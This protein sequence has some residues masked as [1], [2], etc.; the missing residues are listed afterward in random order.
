MTDIPKNFREMLKK[1]YPMGLPRV[2]KQRESED[3]TVKVGMLLEDGEAIEAV[4][5]PTRDSATLCLSSQTGCP[6][7]C[8]FCL[9]GQRPGRN[10]SPAE[11]IGQFLMLAQGLEPGRVNVVFMGMGEPLLNLESLL[12][13]LEFL[14]E[15]IS[16]R[17]ITVSTA[18]LTDGITRLAALVPH[19]KLAVSLNAPDDGT[20][21]SLMPLA[22]N[23][24]I[25]SLMKVMESYPRRRGE[26]ITL[27]YVLIRD[28]NTSDYHARTL[29]DLL[30]TRS[31]IFKINLIPYNRV[32]SLPYSEPL[33]E[34]IQRFI[35]VLVRA[36]LTATVR[37]S[38]G[39]E[40]GAACGQLTASP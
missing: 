28:I 10:L 22:K 11:M 5:M 4:K 23:Q 25:N 3:G 16:P 9:T 21:G 17:R 35:R 20:R 34:E 19:P 33:E 32:D 38:Q 40:I 8:T 2:Q 6:L 24:P 31:G 26:R 18:G 39:R 29:A 7:K 30:A 27:E 15:S 14:Y 12:K 37:R 36:G 1:H 13:T